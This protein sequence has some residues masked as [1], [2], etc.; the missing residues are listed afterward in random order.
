M[1]ELL[2][3]AR[4]LLARLVAREGRITG[5]ASALAFF[6][7]AAAE[8]ATDLKALLA[9]ADNQPRAG[10]LAARETSAAAR[11]KLERASTYPDVTV[12]RNVGREGPG[13][14]RER[15]HGRGG[16]RVIP[17]SAMR[18]GL[19]FVG[20]FFLRAAARR[21]LARAGQPVDQSEEESDDDW[22]AVPAFLRRSKLK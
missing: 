19:A 20:R 1:A 21:G 7:H 2:A 14:A 6:G 5:Y 4:P 8:E 17:T 12:G 18:I 10:A 15:R 16:L 9:S 11:L 22:G 13:A 3:Q